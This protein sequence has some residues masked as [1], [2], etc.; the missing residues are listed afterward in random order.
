[1]EKNG[2][3]KKEKQ[4]L[5]QQTWKI[6]RKEV[7][8]ISK[9]HLDISRLLSRLLCMDRSLPS[10]DEDNFWG[11]RFWRLVWQFGRRFLQRG[12][13]LHVFFSKLQNSCRSSRRFTSSSK[14]PVI[15]L[16]SWNWS[17][18]SKRAASSQWSFIDKASKCDVFGVF[19]MH[20]GPWS[21]MVQHSK[22]DHLISTS[23]SP[24]MKMEWPAKS[25]SLWNAWHC[26]TMYQQHCAGWAT[27]LNLMPF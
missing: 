2:S 16:K 11:V 3:T 21:Q 4:R 5:L 17:E 7:N 25:A 8:W 6:R 1:M 10:F 12:W 20:R 23:N 22:A 15:S 9:Q 27:V 18:V 24:P 26:M 14:R 19:K 13:D